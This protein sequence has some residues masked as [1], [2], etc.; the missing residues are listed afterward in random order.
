[1]TI[2]ANIASGQ[3]AYFEVVVQPGQAV[4][5]NVDSTVSQQV[6]LFASQSGIP[7]STNYDVAGTTNNSNNLQQSLL[8]STLGRRYYILVQGLQGAGTGQPLTIA[9]AAAGLQITSFFS[10]STLLTLTGAGFTPQTTV[11][12]VPVG[13]GNSCPILAT[14]VYA[15]GSS[16]LTANFAP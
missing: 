12:L 5:L 11:Q 1:S 16:Q 14:S 15:L 10:Q 6:Q 9:A 4:Q 2:P 3:S 8:L 7:T 13:S